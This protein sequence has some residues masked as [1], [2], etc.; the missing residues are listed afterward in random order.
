MK[1]EIYMN[2]SFKIL[3]FFLSLFIMDGAAL[4]HAKET[5]KEKPIVSLADFVGT[6]EGDYDE[7][8]V[9]LE[10]KTSG[11]LTITIGDQIMSG[12][13][14]EFTRSKNNSVISTHLLMVCRSGGNEV[15]TIVEFDKDNLDVAYNRNIGL[16]N[17]IRLER[18]K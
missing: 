11:D 2:L 12:Q 10:Y 1:G 15:A 17:I 5:K 9:S 7:Q 18:K 8:K 3:V 4:L 6:W 16:D 13:C 14:D